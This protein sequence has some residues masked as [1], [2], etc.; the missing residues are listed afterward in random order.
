MGRHSDGAVPKGDETI[1]VRKT[2][3]E[4]GEEVVEAQVGEDDAAAFEEERAEVDEGRE[5]VVEGVHGDGVAVQVLVRD[6]KEGEGWDEKGVEVTIAVR[7]EDAKGGESFKDGEGLRDVGPESL[8]GVGSRD[9]EDDRLDVTGVPFES[10]ALDD[11]KVLW[12]G[13]GELGPDPR[14]GRRAQLAARSGEKRGLGAMLDEGEGV[15][16]EFGDVPNAVLD[17]VLEDAMDGRDGETYH[18]QITGWWW[19]RAKEN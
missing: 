12:D 1:A 17:E 16:D 10:V 18:G 13:D 4:G 3:K 6:V 14:F 5:A 7:H 2:T 19:W 11:D 9:V 8:R 15:L